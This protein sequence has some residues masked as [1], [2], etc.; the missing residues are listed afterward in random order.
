MSRLAMLVLCLIIL[1][2]CSSSSLSNSQSE[3]AASRVEFSRDIGTPSAESNPSSLPT[4][5]WR[6]LSVE[7]ADE[8]FA[9]MGSNKNGGGGLWRYESSPLGSE[10]EIINRFIYRD[11][12]MHWITGIENT[13]GGC[14]Y[15]IHRLETNGTLYRVFMCDA[16]NGMTPYPYFEEGANPYLLIDTGEPGDGMVQMEWVWPECIEEKTGEWYFSE[17]LGEME[18][19]RFRPLKAGEYQGEPLTEIDGRGSFYI[20]SFP[21][22]GAQLS[23]GEYTPE[24]TTGMQTYVYD[25]IPW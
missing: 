11:Q 24:T 18:Y 1:V 21:G 9:S 4:E 13:D 10:A 22:Q 23:V 3:S 15:A 6:E 25:A 14:T 7:E 2:G 17:A 19:M 5:E 20:G 12:K 8:F 16:W